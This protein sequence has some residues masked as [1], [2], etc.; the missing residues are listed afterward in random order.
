MADDD[1][2]I[3]SFFGETISAS[4]RH[5]CVHF[6]G[7]ERKADEVERSSFPCGHERGNSEALLQ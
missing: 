7:G 6:E 3:N 4:L 5:Y 2:Y 1:D